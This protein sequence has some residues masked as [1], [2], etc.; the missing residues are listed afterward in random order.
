MR[1][2]IWFIINPISGIR[3]KDDIPVL[4]NKHLDQEKF[5]FTIRYTEFKG[6]AIELT[7][8]AIDEKIDIVC[9]VGGDG[10]VHEVGTT[11][12]G[13][14]TK[15]AILPIGS[16]NGLARHMRI[17]LNIPKAIQ[18]INESHSIA[19][20]T[21]LV[22]DKPVLGFTGFG[23]D[24][25]IAKK[26]DEDKKRGFWTYVKHVFREFFK[27]NPINISIDT[28]GQIKKT[29]A[30]LCTVANTSEFGN[31]FKISPNSDATDGKLELFIL[32]P[33]SWW[34]LPEL[35]V[36]FFTGNSYRSPY[37]EV[38]SFE[39]ARINFSNN[40]MGQY[41]GEPVKVGNELNVQ[42]VPRSLN[43]VIGK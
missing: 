1:Q 29:P 27:Y 41:D 6:H 25:V 23:V 30:V 2:N 12:I 7:K 38:I 14:S 40:K 10:S 17:P 11:L 43:I 33:F 37:A 16:G 26:F 5:E 39:K 4:I 36:Q 18:C 31:G 8:Q 22:N 13:A 32:K 3:R 28:N 42:V 9:A 21:V 35:A 19:M 24:A 20:D 34:R 15:L